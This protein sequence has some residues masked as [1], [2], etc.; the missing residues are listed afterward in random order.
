MEGK[1]L[2]RALKRIKR[3]LDEL[4]SDPLDGVGIAKVKPD[5]DLTYVVNI[6]ISDGIYEGILLQFSM[7]IPT[8]FPIA[9]PEMLMYPGQA[10]GHDFHHHVYEGQ[11][12]YKRFCV[13]IL[14]NAIMSTQTANSGWSPAYTLK[15]L[16]MQVQN[17]LGDPDMS[18]PPG[19]SQI[20]ELKKQLKSYKR[21]FVDEKGNKVVHT[22]SSPF[23]P[24]GV[25][26]DC[27]NKPLSEEDKKLIYVKNALTCYHL[28]TDYLS[29]KKMVLGYPLMITRTQKGLF[30]ISPIPELLSYEGYITQIQ[31]NPNKLDNF[32]G[33]NFKTAM[34]EY[35]NYWLPIFIDEE[36]YKQ[37]KG[38]ILNS[39]SVCRHGVQGKKEY[40][41][42]P[43]DLIDIMPALLNKMIIFLLNGKNHMSN[44]AIEAYCHYIM[45]FNRLCEDYPEIRKKIKSILN[46][47][48]YT[49]ITK[50]NVPDIG[51]TIVLYFF[52]GVKIEESLMH[53]ILDEFFTRHNFWM[54]QHVQQNKKHLIEPLF[55]TDKNMKIAFCLDRYF[56]NHKIIFNSD[57]LLMNHRQYI[58][59]NKQKLMHSMIYKKDRDLKDLR[60]FLKGK[61]FF[62]KMVGCTKET[63]AEIMKILTKE[64]YG[65][66]LLLYTFKAASKFINP[67]YIA[68]LTK[69]YCVLEEEENVN[70]IKEL[71][72]ARNNIISY[73]SLVKEIGF[74]NYFEEGVDDIYYII[75]Y[76][77]MSDKKLYT[78]D[79]TPNSL[80][81]YYDL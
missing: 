5:D 13:D 15:T 56:T 41:F 52:S 22:D 7:K 24:L 59:N 75:K 81:N 78:H 19:K 54:F 45:L 18:K 9:P 76:M 35:Y 61:Y 49:T 72:E 57:I 50:S 77:Q 80:L 66:N 74:E 32:Y 10:F 39:F 65:N 3:D 26:K 1:S 64:H 67:D 69:N 63:K 34:G 60:Q 33:V 47:L 11:N 8:S 53:K 20:E 2:V 58:K 43:Q 6:R 16:F 48:S 62:K 40:D 21:E 42:Q 17:F 55:E 29:D 30:E 38:L 71:N 46:S 51:N 4:E 44:A 68:R 31:S 79:L 14:G 27:L 36:H 28:K 37:N 25:A 23:P 73:R 70:F 12:G